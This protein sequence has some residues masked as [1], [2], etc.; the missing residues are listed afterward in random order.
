MFIK[1]DI[2][3]PSTGTFENIITIELTITVIA[4]Y[5]AQILDFGVRQRIDSI[6]FQSFEGILRSIC[7]NFVVNH[8]SVVSR[9][10]R[11]GTNRDGLRNDDRQDQK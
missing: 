9:N 10:Q 11:D 6:P 8:K 4:I 2:F 1:C 3:I 7:R 5:F